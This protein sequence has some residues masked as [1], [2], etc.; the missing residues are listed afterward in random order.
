GRKYLLVDDSIVRGTTMEALVQI[1]WSMGVKELHLRIAA[2]LIR[3]PCFYG[4][5]M[6]TEQELIASRLAVEE[7]RTRFG[8]NSL[9]FLPLESL[10]S[11][12]PNAHDFCF[13]C[14]GGPRRFLQ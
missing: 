14:M 4:I 10:K 6:S 8:V 2:P 3:K 9:Q 5:N 13:E 1:V 12:L 7:M 11:L